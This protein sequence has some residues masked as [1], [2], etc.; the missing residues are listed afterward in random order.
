MWGILRLDTST[1]RLNKEV[2]C[3]LVYPTPTTLQE[4]NQEK[5]IK[6]TVNT[7]PNEKGAANSPALVS[8]RNGHISNRGNSRSF[9]HGQNRTMK[10]EDPSM[11]YER[12]STHQPPIASSVSD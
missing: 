11:P 3:P 7:I 8:R 12:Q 9:C 5:S 10:M 4:S 2:G 6:T 1:E